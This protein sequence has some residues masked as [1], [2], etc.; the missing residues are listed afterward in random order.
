MSNFPAT[1]SVCQKNTYCY[2]TTKYV[3]RKWC[4][5][6]FITAFYESIHVHGRETT[7]NK[8]H[9]LLDCE[10]RMK[11]TFLERNVYTL[12]RGFRRGIFESMGY[13]CT[14]LLHYF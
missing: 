12:P 10:G 7:F 3:Y 6:D 1:V 4:T 14:G 11:L 9:L 13:F 5:N 8:T 2:L